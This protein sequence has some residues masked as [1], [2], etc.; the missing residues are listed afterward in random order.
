MPTV[1]QLTDPPDA[2]NDPPNPDSD[3]AIVA[4]CPAVICM[5]AVGDEAGEST[6]VPDGPGEPGDVPDPPPEQPASVTTNK[7]AMIFIFIPLS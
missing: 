6:I 4:D 2:E 3:T 5:G 1:K 7:S